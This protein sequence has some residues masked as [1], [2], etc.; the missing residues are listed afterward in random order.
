MTMMNTIET[1]ATFTY[2]TDEFIF[3]N[4]HLEELLRRHYVGLRIFHIYPL[5]QGCN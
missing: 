4:M 3:S 1:T 2:T 5:L